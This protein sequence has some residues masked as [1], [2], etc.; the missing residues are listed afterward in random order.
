MSK[1]RCDVL[2]NQEQWDEAQ[3]EIAR[4]RAGLQAAFSAFYD[5]SDLPGVAEPC[6]ACDHYDC[7]A[8][9]AIKEALGD[10]LVYPDQG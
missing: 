6:A 5:D 3:A 9:R 10:A 2:Y 4:L 1:E 7:R 8:G